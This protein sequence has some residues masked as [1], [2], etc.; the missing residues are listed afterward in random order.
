MIEI[1]CYAALAILSLVNIFYALPIVLNTS[2]FSM[3]IIIAGSH[4]SAI[5]MISNFKAVYVDKKK[6]ASDI[7]MV[8]K[9]DAM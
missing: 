2:A 3:L 8:T 4:R 5:E 6:L 7:E 9:E 1:I